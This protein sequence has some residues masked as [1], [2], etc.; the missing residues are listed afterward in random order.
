MPGLYYFAAT[1]LAAAVL[2]GAVRQ[3]ALRTGMLDHPVERSAHISSTPLAGGIAIVLVFVIATSF[4]FINGSIPY[5]ET[6]AL[7]AGILIAGVGLVDDLRQLDIRWRVPAQFIAA[8]WAVAWLGEIPPIPLPGLELSGLLLSCLAIVAMVWLMNLYNFMDGIDG[9]AGAELVFVN[10]VSL[11]LV[12]NSEDRV[13]ALSSLA[14]LGA[15]LGFLVWNWPPAKIFM[16]DV[17]SGFVGFVLGVLAIVS[18]Q[19]GSLSLW[20]WLL[21]LGVF[22]VDATVTLLRRFFSG[23]KWYEGHAS[24][25]YQKAARK[26]KSH[27]KVT[28]TVIAINCLWLAP[29]AWLSESY[30]EFGIYFSM[31]G[32]IPLICLAWRLG[33]GKPDRMTE[34]RN[35]A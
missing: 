11:L 25:G 9:L 33:A 27:G 5:T 26:Y 24:H 34:V 12:I 35:S 29:L 30:P 3:L 20:T 18:M 31:L 4:N 8:I 23:Q 15:G 2:T 22:V 21:L 6:M 7:A 19:N 28:I 14:L 1:A 17:G 10:V 16:G 32:I 13:L